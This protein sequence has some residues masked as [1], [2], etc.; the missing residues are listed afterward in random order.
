MQA[1][2]ESLLFSRELLDLEKKV[3]TAESMVKSLF[4]RMK[5]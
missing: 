4:M 2:G 3:S 5:C 1:L